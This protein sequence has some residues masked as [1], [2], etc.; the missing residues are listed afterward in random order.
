MT[1]GGVGTPRL[2][3]RS[4][5]NQ[6]IIWYV[7]SRIALCSIHPVVVNEFGPVFDSNSSCQWLRCVSIFG[8]AMRNAQGGPTPIRTGEKSRESCKTGEND[9]ISVRVGLWYSRCAVVW[10]LVWKYDPDLSTLSRAEPHP[11]KLMLNS[12]LEWLIKLV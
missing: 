2:L 5:W 1:Y 9:I 4:H 11:E 8:A 6:R 3:I 7:F 12:T 10:G